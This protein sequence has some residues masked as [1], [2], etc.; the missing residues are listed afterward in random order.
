M[1]NWWTGG[2]EDVSAGGYGSAEDPSHR[3]DEE[4]ESETRY[5]DMHFS[6]CE[7]SDSVSLIGESSEEDSTTT[8]SDVD[9]RSDENAFSRASKILDEADALRFQLDGETFFE[10]ES[11]EEDCDNSYG[12]A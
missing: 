5:G 12:R 1:H 2:L 7:S 4:G 10:S 6:D 11:D 3:A 8:E 9:V